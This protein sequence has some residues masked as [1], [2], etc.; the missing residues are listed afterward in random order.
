MTRFQ[1]FVYSLIIEAI[2]LHQIIIW[3]FNLFQNSFLV[4]RE[5]CII[6]LAAI[7]C[8]ILCHKI[9]TKYRIVLMLFFC[10]CYVNHSHRW[11][12]LQKLILF[13]SLD[14]LVKRG[15][16]TITVPVN[17]LNN[18]AKKI[19]KCS[20]YHA[21]CVHKWRLHVFQYFREHIKSTYRSTQKGQ[22]HE[23]TYLYQQKQI[24]TNI[25]LHSLCTRFPVSLP[26]PPSLVKRDCSMHSCET[27]YA[28]YGS[29]AETFLARPFG[30]SR[31]AFSLSCHQRHSSE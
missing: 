27:P 22:H 3:T 17:V 11:K 25:K 24:A 12:F 19:F 31:V 6:A 1:H 13:L 14:N 29:W 16:P 8:T 28:V 18:S 30:V 26:W 9:F 2:Q 23:I 4:S 10:Q 21:R 7:D 20:V 5:F 15:S